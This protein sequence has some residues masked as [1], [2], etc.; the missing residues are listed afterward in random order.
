[1]SLALPLPVLPQQPPT[2]P[3]IRIPME[4]R[5]SD[6]Q[7]KAFVRA[8]VEVRRLQREAGQGGGDSEEAIES[9]RREVIEAAGL[10][11]ELYNRIFTARNRNPH[12]DRRI[13][14]FLEEIEPG[15]K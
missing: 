8:Y 11:P 5:F 10:R 13:R 15:A 4:E 9:R 7:L 2:G 12:L 3:P 6:D 14:A 1:M